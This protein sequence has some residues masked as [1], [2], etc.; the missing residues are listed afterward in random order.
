MILRW[1]FSC[2]LLT[3]SCFTLGYEELAC[4]AEDSDAYDDEQTDQ[5]PQAEEQADEERDSKSI[6]AGGLKA[7]E[8]MPETG[9]PRSNVERELQESDEKDAGRGLEFA[10]LDGSFGYQ[11]VSPSAF[12]DKGLLPELK[13]SGQSGLAFGGAAGLRI[14]Y[15]SLG[16]RFRFTSA[17]EFMMWTLGAEASLRIPVGA[18]EPYVLIGAGYAHIFGARTSDDLLI[19]KVGGIDLRIGGGLDYYLSRTFSVGAQF[20]FDALLLKRAVQSSELC[21][22]V[23]GCQYDAK[24]SAAGLSVTPSLVAGLHF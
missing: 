4:A 17:A 10:W 11:F 22:D 2:A 19:K 1:S 16:A 7:P 12:K 23:D 13:S 5:F 18:F 15:F 3:F 24:G 8:A 21:E 6:S 20:A 14:L 9:Q